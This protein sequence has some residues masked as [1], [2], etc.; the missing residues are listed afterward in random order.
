MKDKVNE[1]INIIDMTAEDL[2]FP[3]FVRY[4]TFIS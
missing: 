4:N 3:L 2:K 1:L